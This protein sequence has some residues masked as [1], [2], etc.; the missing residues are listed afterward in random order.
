M[1]FF[2]FFIALANTTSYEIAFVCSVVAR[3]TNFYSF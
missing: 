1:I 2:F 3:V